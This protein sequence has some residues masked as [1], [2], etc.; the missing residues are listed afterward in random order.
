MIIEKRFTENWREFLPPEE[1]EYGCSH[2]YS[3][4]ICPACGVTLCWQ[5]ASTNW[6]GDTRLSHMDNE[7]RTLCPSCGR[8]AHPDQFGWT[9]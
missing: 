7:A 1:E 5:C 8:Y 3:T 2:P 9:T 6:G 4:F